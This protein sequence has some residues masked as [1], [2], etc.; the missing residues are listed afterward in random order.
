MRQ[1]DS[2]DLWNLSL[3]LPDFSLMNSPTVSAKLSLTPFQQDFESY[4]ILT[5]I[6]ADTKVSLDLDGGDI[7]AAIDLVVLKGIA[8]GQVTS[9]QFYI[10]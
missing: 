7:G 9:Q 10:G 8:A 6:G 4:I 5:Q 2:L 3:K 1:L